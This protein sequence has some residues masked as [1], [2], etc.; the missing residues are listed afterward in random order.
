MQKF[1]SNGKLL[2]TGEY[3]VLDGALSLVLPTKF[4]QSL[5]I[6]PINEPKIVWQSFDEKKA[7]W[8]NDEISFDEITSGFSN[9]RNEVS[10]RIIQIINAVKTLNQDFLSQ[11]KGFKISTHLTFPK[12]WGL[13][14]SSTL[15]NN[16]AQWTHVN[17]FEL[18]EK[19]FGGSGYDIACA[20][21]NHP[22]TYQLQKGKPHITEVNF[23]PPF[24]ENLYFVYLN[25]KQNSRDGIASYR[26][27]KGNTTSAISEIN[28]ITSKI[29]NSIT[30]NDFECLIE[31]HE[32]IISKIIK[33]KPVKDL[34]FSD[35]NGSTKSLGAWGG[36]FI[37]VTSTENPSSYFKNKGFSTIVPFIDMIL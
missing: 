2:I 36:D 9:P 5:E 17:A 15:I 37:L 12:N 6:E 21:N 20:Q 23:N 13:G 29:I 8:F 27:N 3:L 18:L 24:K 30:L 4:G 33:L 26:S 11:K 34:L 19:T 35:F 32:S 7:I 28:D 16:I 25:K 14:T 22:I 1:Y 31:S 10:K